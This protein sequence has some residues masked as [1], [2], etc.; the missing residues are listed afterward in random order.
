MTSRSANDSFDNSS[1]NN[2]LNSGDSG[3]YCGFISGDDRD[4]DLLDF[5]YPDQLMANLMTSVCDPVINCI[6]CGDGENNDND[7]GDRRTNHVYLD[8]GMTA[9]ISTAREAAIN[10]V[11]HK[12]RGDTRIEVVDES[13]T[14]IP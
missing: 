7:G 1:H 5:L 9:S 4:K 10:Y 3:G 13:K 11:H 14:M 8:S 12:G 6:Q 2:A